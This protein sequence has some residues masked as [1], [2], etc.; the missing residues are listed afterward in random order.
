MSNVVIQWLLRHRDATGAVVGHRLQP[1]TVGRRAIG[2][3]LDLGDQP[4]RAPLHREH[5]QR[6]GAVERKYVCIASRVEVVVGFDVGEHEALA[7]ER[8]LQTA[9]RSAPRTV[10]WLPSAPTTNEAVTSWSP[11]RADA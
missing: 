1:S 3:R 10:L 8:T 2:R 5:H 9:G 11:S 6:P 4:E 7:L